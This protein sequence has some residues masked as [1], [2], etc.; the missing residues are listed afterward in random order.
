VTE[1]E[2]PRLLLGVRPIAEGQIRDALFGTDR[3]LTVV[4]SAVE[5]AELC[6]LAEHH[7]ADAVLVSPNLSGLEAG[8]C[9]RLRA[10]GLCVVGLALDERDAAVLAALGIDAVL[11]PP[12]AGDE[13]AHACQTSHR[14]EEAEHTSQ[15]MAHRRPPA[16]TDAVGRE[17]SGS[18]VAVVAAGRSAGGS[19]CAC[20]LAALL[21]RRWPTLLVECDLGQGGLALRVGADPQQGSL[22][23]LVRAG[24]GADGEELV[25]MLARW[26]IAPERWPALLVAP[27]DVDRDLDEL[28]EPGAIRSALAA[29]AST[30]PLVIA[31]VGSLLATAG[32]V[33]KVAHCHREAL[34][35]ADSVLLV[36]GA[37]DDQLHAGGAQL[38]RLTGDLGVKPE[39]LRICVN[40]LGAPGA[41]SRTEAQAALAEELANLQLGVDGWLPYDRR[42]LVRARGSGLPLALARRHSP[43][44]RTLSRVLDMLF[45]ADQPVTRRRQYALRVPA[46]VRR[47]R[48]RAAH[49]TH[50]LEIDEEVPLPWRS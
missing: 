31:D 17:K 24:P 40:G 15:P 3:T 19:E 22:L 27:A 11:T 33:P 5:A 16:A 39:R 41:A 45:I 47:N 4:A 44:A 23:G 20:S 25:R 29:A 50:A 42:A 7:S 38:A 48:A 43:Y 6:A 21:D 9:A 49:A 12:L 37:R 2:R 46:P 36:I 30:Y 1:L 18:V 14:S 28:A 10:A 13:L 34:V 35:S 8:H 32:E 26:T